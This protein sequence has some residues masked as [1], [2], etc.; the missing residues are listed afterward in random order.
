[1]ANLSW[2]FEQSTLLLNG[3]LSEATLL[4]LWQQKHSLCASV[5]R[6]NLAGLTRVDSSG[7]ALLINF[8][9]AAEK[10]IQLIGVGNQ[11]NQLIDLYNLRDLIT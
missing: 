3:E 6:I 8:H 2:Q 10:P 11:V 5:T 4:P 9:Q 1:M 7:L